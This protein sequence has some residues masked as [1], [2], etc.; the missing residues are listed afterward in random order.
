MST[1]KAQPSK[2]DILIVDDTP[3]NL[4]LLSN[5]L[6]ESGYKVRSAL[7]GTLALRA[8]N[9]APPDLILL[10]ITMPQMNGYDICKSLKSDEHTEG[11]PIIFLSAL[12]RS[13]DKVKAFQVGGVDYITKPFQVEE[14]LVRVENQ[15]TL[16]KLQ[17]QLE[18][19]VKERTA[20]LEAVNQELNLEIVKRKRVQKKL[21]QMALH[22]NLTGLP[23]R[24]FL[25]E[26]LVQL[27]DRVKQKP[28]EQFAV[29]FL[30]CD[31]FKV[32]NDSLGHLVGDRLL[33]EIARRLQSS[34]P[35]VETLARLGGDEFTIVLA[36]IRDIREAT[37]LAQQLLELFNHPFYLDPHEVFINTSIGIVLGT[38]SYELPENLL[39]DADVA[40]YRAKEKGRACYEV[41]DRTMH[42]RVLSFLQLDTDLR[43]A[44]ER[45]E[46]MV[47]YQPIVAL[48]TGYIDG[49][50]A[51]ARWKHPTRGF[52]SP[53]EFIPA[54]EETGLIIPIGQW[55]LETA[56][57]Q[58]REWQTQRRQ[59]CSADEDALP[60][61][62][63]VNLSVRQFVQANLLEQIDE[64]LT[65][66]QLEG[67]SLK[68]EITESAI[69]E[70]TRSVATLLQELKSRHIQL[71][72][73]D[74]GTGYS[75]LSYLHRFPVDT[76]KI[77]RSFIT[78]MES[79]RKN[80]EIVG[81]IITLA[82]HLGMGIVAEGIETQ[83][84]ARQIRAIGGKWGQG[85]LFSPA[86]ESAAAGTILDRQYRF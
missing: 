83:P 39:R 30:D 52:I 61:T 76:L 40:M 73:D 38:P 15:L 79:G 65:R 60:L 32:V 59:R 1:L 81:A 33:V 53:M 4:R 14:V 9:A 3:D 34:V 17:T 43:R 26:R 51:L 12:D 72:I 49:F 6:S 2:G 64:I 44:M 50:E 77:D 42:D 70:N 18:Q 57:R 63:S 16:K 62:M 45:K 58:L 21:L 28:S 71:S 22:D 10:D 86:I 75:S 41:F 69:M 24:A 66:H 47:Y 7:N 11:I 25:L 8:V 46:L 13:F 29:L 56:C 74:F 20:Q 5:I 36:D 82:H 48:D 19:R 31:R 84:Q 27:L 55:V 80:K 23:N 68:L 35:Q 37:E 67:G 54:A 85:L 78:R